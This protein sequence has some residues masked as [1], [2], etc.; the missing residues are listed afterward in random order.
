MPQSK[1]GSRPSSGKK[2]SSKKGSKKSGS[3]KRHSSRDRSKTRLAE[4]RLS[5]SSELQRPVLLRMDPCQISEIDLLGDF[6]AYSRTQNLHLDSE[7]KPIALP[8]LR[9]ISTMSTIADEFYNAYFSEGPIV[10]DGTKYNR[11]EWIRDHAVGESA[12]LTEIESESLAEIEPQ[13]EV[14]TPAILE[15]GT[16]EENPAIKSPSQSESEERF[17]DAL[18]EVTSREPTLSP[19]LFDKISDLIEALPIARQDFKKVWNSC[20]RILA[21]CP[22]LELYIGKDPTGSDP[23]SIPNVLIG[24]DPIRNLIILLSNGFAVEEAI[25]S[26]RQYDRIF[27]I[28][29]EVQRSAKILENLAVQNGKT[30]EEK[31]D[32]S[33]KPIAGPSRSTP[34][35]QF[36]DEKVSAPT[37]SHNPDSKKDRKGGSTGRQVRYRT[38]WV[39]FKKQSS[40]RTKGS[41]ISSKCYKVGPLTE[42]KAKN[43]LQSASIPGA[44]R[45]IIDFKRFSVYKVE[46]IR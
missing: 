9:T 3:K 20:Q 15:S 43:L 33:Q 25:L 44:V 17:V 41:V 34:D 7:E 37:K 30:K 10:F 6:S 35:T 26:Y 16:K 31:S 24:E 29:R 39:A 22:R 14:V 5:H 23:G 11:I 28:D 4:L 12:S 40:S 42:E 21:K 27:K 38:Y 46:E 36:T 1:K 2:D 18:T 13:I 8:Q 32:D 19:E 45:G